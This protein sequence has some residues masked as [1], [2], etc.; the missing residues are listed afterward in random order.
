[1]FY[2]NNVV[3]YGL[4]AIRGAWISGGIEFNFPTGHTYTTVSPVSWEL[5]ED[6]GGAWLA[7]GN[8]CRVSRMEWWVKLTLEPGRR[9]LK[10]EVWLHNPMPYRQ[11]HWFW[12]NSAVPARDDLRL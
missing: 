11:R 5:G 1:M 2:R 6:E 12:N 9:R 10:E 7:V 8:I 3:K 4:I